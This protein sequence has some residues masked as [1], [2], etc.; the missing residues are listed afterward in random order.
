VVERV[1]ISTR[2]ETRRHDGAF[3]RKKLIVIVAA[4]ELDDGARLSD[5]A[6][7]THT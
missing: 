1:L 3:L 4:H 2:V 7:V 5:R 6:D